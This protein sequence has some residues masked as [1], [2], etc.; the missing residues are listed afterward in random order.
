MV[1]GDPVSGKEF[2]DRNKE[3]GILFSTLDDFEKGQKRNIA[4]IGL[5]KIGKTSL[6]KE[7]IRRL[8]KTKPKI[9][10]LDIYLPE[11]NPQNF[12]KN[13]VGS[14]IVELFRIMDLQL[15][16]NIPTLESAM[17]IIE[18]DY[19]RTTLAIKNLVTYLELNKNEE[20]FDYLFSLFE[21][22]PTLA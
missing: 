12:F 7:F 9:I 10:C 6:I 4:I 19:P 8:H 13:C 15:K 22:S 20:A 11:Q 16:T 14:I 2:F 1:L 18:Q 21:T 3:Q 5:R 17:I